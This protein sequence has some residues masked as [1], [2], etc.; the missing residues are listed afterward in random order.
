LALPAPQVVA[1]G[2]TGTTAPPVPEPRFKW[3]QGECYNCTE[4]FTKEHL[5]VCPVKG[6]FLLELDMPVATDLLDDTTPQISLNALS[7]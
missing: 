2:T 6:I 5:E 1:G 7:C 4:K 3:V